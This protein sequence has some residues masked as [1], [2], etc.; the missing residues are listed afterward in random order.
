M[1]TDS[2]L[3]ITRP[4]SSTGSFTSTTSNFEWSTVEL[5]ALSDRIRTAVQRNGIYG[6]STNDIESLDA[7]LDRLLH[8]EAT[9]KPV[10]FGVII[11]GRVDKMLEVLRAE[12]IMFTDSVLRDIIEKASA[13][14]NK[15]QFRF[16]PKYAAID[17]IRL[18]TLKQRWLIG[19]NIPV[20]DAN[21]EVGR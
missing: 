14:R 19:N 20:A 7:M 10:D 2:P 9:L 13:M 4:G 1:F 15:W 16:G 17:E 11:Q 5:L 8:D 3:S 12:K 21:L 18:D 6:I